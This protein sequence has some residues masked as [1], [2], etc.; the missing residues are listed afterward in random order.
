MSEIYVFDALAVD[1][2]TAGLAGALLPRSAIFT[3]EAGGAS[4][5]T[6]E[7]GYD[8]WGKW[9]AL[10]VGNII[11]AWVPVRTTPEISGGAIVTSV[12]VYTVKPEAQLTKAQRY[13]YASQ[14]GNSR[15]QM[16]PSGTEVAVVSKPTGSSRWKIKCNYGTG[17]MESAA[18]SYEVTETIPA[19]SDGMEQVIPSWEIRPQLFVIQTVTESEESVTVTAT[20]ITYQLLKNICQY[21]NY[22]ALTL[23]QALDGIL[24]HCHA[25][26][27]FQAYTD[28][29]DSRTGVSWD[30]VNP[31]DA[32]LNPESGAMARWGAQLIRDN[33]EFYFLR[34]AG[35]DRGMRVEYAK[36]LSGIRYTEDISNLV[37][38]VIPVGEDAD[39]RPLYLENAGADTACVDSPR[40]DDYA[41]P[42][43]TVLHCSDC[44]VGGDVTVEIARARMQAQAE[45][46]MA[47]GG[48]LP[49]I[50]LELDYLAMGDT[51][52]YK[53][54]RALDRCFLYD[55]VTVDYTPL[56]IS[57]ALELTRLEWDCV[58]D[59]AERMEFGALRGTAVHVATWQIPGGI[60]GSKL[61][62]GSVGAAQIGDG[63]VVS[64]HI[65]AGS[66]NTDALQAGSVTADKIAAGAI[67]AGTIS[68]LTAYLN[69]ITAETITTDTLAAAFASFGRVVAQ[70]I[71][72]QKMSTDQLAAVMASIVTLTAKVGEFDFATVQ[73]MLSDAMIVQQGYADSVL[74]TNLAVTS[75]NML[76]ATIGHL[77]LH[78]SDGKYYEINV[79]SDGTIGT[80]E[81]EAT[82]AEIS[83][84]QLSDGRQIVSQVVNA[85]S[86][87][88][89]T[90][91]AK[92]A[93]LNTVLTNA[94]NAGKI[95]A[96]EAVIASASIPTLYVTSLKALGDSLD[97]SANS[98]INFLI[99]QDQQIS[100]A[101]S[102][103]QM[104]AGSAQNLAE[105]AKATA[106]AAEATAQDVR[107][108]MTFDADG[109]R[110]GAADSAYSTLTDEEGFHILQLGEKI[111][112]FAKRRL[113]TEEIRIGRVAT[114][115]NRCVIREAGDGGLIIT[116]E[117]LT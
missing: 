30:M 78:G 51:E 20:H 111:G 85:K 60:S 43:I 22:G 109:L 58:R 31:I 16:I 41:H 12:E 117:G 33:K 62:G 77:V 7:H 105:T 95:T 40:I 13:L 94:L 49:E 6:I 106:D 52:E 71:Q 25:P 113:A 5:L 2:S 70:D 56:G 21:I 34:R 50:T 3:E 64:R 88:G 114:T 90:V 44:K 81:V 68:A 38:R 67:Q 108:W 92:Q 15:Q 103:A 9:E 115:Q 75:A 53:A 69:D 8:D 32:M 10:R 116:V 102:E 54:Y 47:N 11:K 80:K 87:N 46:L 59:R 96:A 84:G 66:I 28:I 98:S 112:S 42:H 73:N 79:G 29:A 36:N 14:T 61:V 74:I 72:A 83:A 23:Q 65:Q 91:K 48:D 110:Q 27:D 104:T 101:A 4:E 26:H 99:T 39:G 35:R 37:T 55:S 63:V 1:T 17:W 82:A 100:E 89:E 107:R 19:T 93:I 97:I 18:I 76:D 45:E 86:L 24:T 57:A